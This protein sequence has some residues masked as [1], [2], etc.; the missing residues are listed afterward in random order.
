MI[1]TSGGIDMT[2]TSIKMKRILEGRIDT[3]IYRTSFN[4]D[5]DQFRIEWK[6]TKEGITITLPSVIAKYNERGD[7]AIDELVEH[8]EEALRIMN[9]THTLKGMEKNI[10]P[11]IRSTSF[12]TKTKQGKK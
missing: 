2:M 11:V 5:K 10:F 12:P 6:E 4:R 3:E 9:E 8:I 7:V 1:K